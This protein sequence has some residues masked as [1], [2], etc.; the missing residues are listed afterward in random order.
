[1]NFVVHLIFPVQKRRVDAAPMLLSI[2]ACVRTAAVMRP[3][4]V[5]PD[6]QNL[7]FTCKQLR[8]EATEERVR[9]LVPS[10]NVGEDPDEALRQTPMWFDRWRAEAQL[11]ISSHRRY[12]LPGD[13]GDR[14]KVC[15]PG[16]TNDFWF[17]TPAHV[18]RD[19]QAQPFGDRETYRRQYRL[20]NSHRVR[21]LGV[22]INVL[23]D[24]A[25]ESF[26]RLDVS[27]ATP[28]CVKFADKF[29]LDMANSIGD[30]VMDAKSWQLNCFD[31]I[32]VGTCHVD[33]VLN[34]LSSKKKANAGSIERA[35]HPWT[36][37]SVTNVDEL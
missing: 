3:F 18:H 33:L 37:L 35:A 4:L 27:V 15:F 10:W 8:A 24:T 9:R 36:K 5:L 32:K 25:A 34:S 31:K 6:F 17:V 13:S 19:P 20:R 14:I 30:F 29:L 23:Q 11:N 7:M 12:R 16:T 22:D 28:E 1:M 21:D 2:P 26:H